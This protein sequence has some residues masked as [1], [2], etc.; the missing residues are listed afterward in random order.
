MARVKDKVALVTGAASGLGLEDARV[1]AS[2]GARVV[3]TDINSEKGEAAAR[4]IGPAA[5]FMSHDVS[6]EDDWKEVM[7]Q[8]EEAHGDLDILVNNAG[9][10]VLSSPEACTLDEFRFA[11]AVMSEG[12]FLGMK[13][14]MPLLKQGNG[15]SIINMS[16][17][18]SHVGFPIFFAY[19][20]AKGAVRA[21]TKSMA[22]H[23]QAEGLPVRCNSVHAGAIETPMVQF[24]QGRTDAPIEVPDEGVLPADSLGSPRDVANMV[25]YLASDESRFVTGAEFLI[26]NGLIARPAM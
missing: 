1:L 6:S 13:Y 23:C 15:G 12:V 5:S 22:V 19:S 9:V 2:E 14:A 24:A 17:T 20:A 8:V 4:S 26:D 3:L 11:N 16:S 7:I 10:V 25:L 21:M 18:A